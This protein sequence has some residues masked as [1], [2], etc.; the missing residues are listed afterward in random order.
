MNSMYKARVPNTSRS[1][2]YRD[3]RFGNIRSRSCMT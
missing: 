1:V 2:G 3:A